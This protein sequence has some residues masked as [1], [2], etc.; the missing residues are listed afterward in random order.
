MGC[1]KISRFK[2]NAFIGHSECT[3]CL[4]RDSRQ[5]TEEEFKGTELQSGC[6]DID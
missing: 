6:W 5:I 4:C 3:K 1:E 2:Y